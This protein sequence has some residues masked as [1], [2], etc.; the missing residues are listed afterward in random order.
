MGLQ[1]RLLSLLDKTAAN[2]DSSSSL[3]PGVNDG[4]FE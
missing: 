2:Q 3:L 4:K 1:T